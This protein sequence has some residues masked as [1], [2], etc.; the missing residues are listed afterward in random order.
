MTPSAVTE[1][2][3]H[4]AQ[5][6]RWWAD[7]ADGYQHVHERELPTDFA[8]WSLFSIPNSDLDVLP[9]VAG[10]DVVELGAGGAQFSLGLAREGARCTA[11]DF[12]P[13]ELT[14]AQR[15]IDSVT[16]QDGVRPDVTLVKADVEQTGLPAAS[17]DVAVSDYGAS[18]FADPLRW[19]PEAARLLRSGGRLA[20]SAI[21]PI[22]ELCWHD[23]AAMTNEMVK[24]YFGLHRIDTGGAVLFNLPYGEWI[25][26]FRRS[27]FTVVDMVETR[28][29]EGVVETTYRS[30]GQIE[31]ARQWPAEMIWV[32]DRD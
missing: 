24:P 12:S 17:F 31:W 11:I 7:R 25:R 26:L 13:E 29:R 1:P 6:E 18:M 16:E 8:M 22:H 14:H 27:G 2:A 19:V 4:I 30:R 3:D 28:P 5:N 23:R 9:D 15:L 21:S 32:L 10:L 20:F